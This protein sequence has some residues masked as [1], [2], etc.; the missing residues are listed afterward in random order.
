[1]KASGYCL[2]AACL[3]ENFL[4]AVANADFVIATGKSIMLYANSCVTVRSF[5]CR[6]VFAAGVDCTPSLSCDIT[7]ILLMF[8]KSISGYLSPSNLTSSVGVGVAAS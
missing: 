4:S 5:R 7:P 2:D 3:F 8:P 1:M 6:Q